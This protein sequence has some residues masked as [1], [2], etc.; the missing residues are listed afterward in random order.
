MSIVAGDLVAYCAVDMPEDET[1]VNGGG[2]DVL[3]RIA[4][5]DIAANDSLEVI[6]SSAADTTQTI[7]VT[8]RLA[9][10][11]QSSQTVTLTGTSLV[12]LSVLGTIERVQKAALSA[13]CAGTVTVRRSSAGATV[14]TIPP[15]ERG[16]KR[17]FIA[18]FS[19]VAPKTYYMKFFWKNTHG[20]LSLLSS[21]V[22]ESASPTGLVTH[23]VAN[24]VSDSATTA[25]RITAPTSGQLG[26]AQTFDSTDKAIPGTDL[27]SGVAIGVWLSFALG[28]SQS[29]IKN[30][31]TS[32]L[33]GQ[34]V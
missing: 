4:F 31:Y 15:A 23:Q 2:I 7:T 3:N 10:G 18:A 6:S 9:T 26:N 25:N 13:S 29:P 8:G 17:L 33:A 19:A 1:S 27:A 32:Q 22:Q 11:S 5:T 12:A 20:T 30:T 16:F 14:A 34:S 21:L 28:G 24:A